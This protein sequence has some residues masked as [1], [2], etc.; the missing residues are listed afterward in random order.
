[1]DFPGN[2]WQI[3]NSSQEHYIRKVPQN[4]KGLQTNLLGLPA[5]GLAVRIDM[6][7]DTNTTIK[8]DYQSVFR[9]LGSLGEPYEIKTQAPFH[10]SQQTHPNT[11]PPQGWN[12]SWPDGINGSVLREVHQ[13][14]KVDDILAQL[15]G[16]KRFSKLDANSG[17]WHQYFQQI[18]LYKMPFGISSAS[19][20]F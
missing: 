8:R 14:L 1:M 2:H 15:T 3:E 19:E 18:L 7:E 13:L 16:A 17:L 10:Y 9:R 4:I 6:I 5:L 12:R 11:T 20:Y